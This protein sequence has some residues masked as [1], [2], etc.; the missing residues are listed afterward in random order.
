MTENPPTEVR[1]LDEV[2]VKAKKVEK[3]PAKIVLPPFHGAKRLENDL[4]H[5]HLDIRFDIPN[6][7]AHGKA[8]LTLRPY[9]Y[10]TDELTLDAKSMKFHAVKLNGPSGPSLKFHNTDS[11]IFIDLGRT[12]SRQDTYKVYLDYT[13][14]P[15]K[16]PKGGSDAIRSDQGLYFIDPN[17]TD[18]EKPTEIWT[19][20]E[21][22]SNSKWVPT[23]DAPNE[24]QTHDFAITVPAKFKTLSN[25]RFVRSHDNSDGTRTD[26]WTMDIPHAPYL[27][28]IAAGD[29]AVVRDTWNGKPIA[30][31]VEPKYKEYATD[32]FPHTKE[33]LSF[34]SQITGVPYPW[35]KYDQIVVRDF[36]SGAMEN[37]T[38][39]VFHESVQKTRRELIGDKSNE[40]IVAHEMFHHWFGDYV[41]CESWANI[42]LNEGFANYAEYLWL[43]HK[44]GKEEADHHLLDELEGYF[45]D[46]PYHPL[47]DHHYRD[48]EDM[49]DGHSYN[50]GGCTLHMLRKMVGD[51]AFF[52]SLKRYLTEHAL[53]PVEVDELRMAFEDQL[54]EDLEW[55]FDQWYKKAGHPELTVTHRY[56]N[57]TQTLILTIEQTQKGLRVPEVFRLPMYVDIYNSKGQA[58]RQFIEMNARKQVFRI[59]VDTEPTVV[60]LDPEGTLVAQIE[61]PERSPIEWQ[62]LYNFSPSYRSRKYAIYALLDAYRDQPERQLRFAKTLLDD[63]FWEFRQLGLYLLQSAPK[64]PVTLHK[65]AALAENDSSVD[66]KAVALQI[67]ARTG[68]AKY[69]PLFKKIAENKDLPYHVTGQALIG[70]T[71]LDPKLAAKYLQDL[72]DVN[73]PA[74][75]VA[76]GKLYAS[77][78]DPRHLAFFEK[79][80]RNVNGF[81][82]LDFYS[83]YLTTAFQAAPGK[84]GDLFRKLK[85]IATDMTATPDQRFSAT[86]QMVDFTRQVSDHSLLPTVRKYLAEIKEKEK[87]PDL[88]AAYSKMF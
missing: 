36:V 51:E 47:I 57:D 38:A 71:N 16:G 69:A 75:L 6:Q 31:Y 58:D 41:T 60:E 83:S 40:L 52:A 48:R 15:T 63:R 56:D 61:Y 87:L 62:E 35:P 8:I 84:L 50:K 1:Q 18:P 55:F 14:Y 22:E 7:T 19:Q 49:F 54:G 13:A 46:R 9:F 23:I 3:D 45:G 29:Y 74:I 34:F 59:A 11:Q 78:P 79:N 73:E 86:K 25:G 21:T 72:E 64:A 67:L 80:L 81:D 33:L 5:T 70:I 42:T 39:V 4:I 32:I 24:R 77:N 37:T 17:D 44:Y 30:Y 10:P 28:M 65:I 2:V 20:G 82:A 68:E 53:S 43:E 85:D 66:V 76:M 26:Y 27:M 88:K 12:Y